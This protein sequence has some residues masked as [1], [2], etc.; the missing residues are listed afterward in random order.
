MK[1]LGVVRGSLLARSGRNVA[2]AGGVRARGACGYER[3]RS[4]ARSASNGTHERRS[5]SASAMGAQGGAL[6]S[7]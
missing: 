2:R 4:V 6:G 7:F 1:V 3:A 5:A